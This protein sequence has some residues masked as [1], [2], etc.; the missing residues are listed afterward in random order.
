MYIS[1]KDKEVY[2]KMK[3]TSL[4]RILWSDE[5]NVAVEL[6]FLDKGSNWHSMCPFDH[7]FKEAEDKN[8]KE[9]LLFWGKYR[10]WQ[11]RKI[12]TIKEFNEL[13]VN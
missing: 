2:S 4:H 12:Y 13:F 11:K 8:D 1:L 7:E 5:N 9:F 3:Y 6:E 10:K